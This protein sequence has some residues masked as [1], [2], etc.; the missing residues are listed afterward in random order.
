MAAK[1]GRL[2]AVKR[3]EGNMK[4]I[5]RSGILKPRKRAHYVIALFRTARNKYRGRYGEVLN[6]HFEHMDRLFVKPVH[7]LQDDN[8]TPAAGGA[9]DKAAYGPSDDYGGTL[10]NNDGIRVISYPP[11]AHK[12]GKNP[13][14]Q[15][16]IYPAVL[17]RFLRTI[18]RRLRHEVIP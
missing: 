12:I 3:F 1:R 9:A 15:R 7:I 11:A 13:G 2:R 8:W 16:K 14:E 17:R 6:K 4:K 10:Q 5:D 18:Q